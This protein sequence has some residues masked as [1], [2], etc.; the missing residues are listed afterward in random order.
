METLEHPI[1]IFGKHPTSAMAHYQQAALP[2]LRQRTKNAAVAVGTPVTR[3]PPHRSL[4]AE[5]PHKAPTSGSNA[6]SLFGIRVES[7]H[8]WEPLRSQSVHSLASN[9]VALTPSPQ[10]L[11]PE[12]IHLILESIEFPMVAWHSVV[13]EVSLYHAT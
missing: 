2:A 12:S 7:S 10:R 3:R 8:G 4:R 5:L 6:Q 13:L 9:P 11:K 1:K